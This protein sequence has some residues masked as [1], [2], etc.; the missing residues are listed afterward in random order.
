MRMWDWIKQWLAW[1]DDDDDDDNSDDDVHVNYD[2]DHDDGDD[3][4]DDDDDD[5]DEFGEKSLVMSLEWKQK[6]H[7]DGC[8]AAYAWLTSLSLVA[9]SYLYRTCTEILR[10]ANHVI[11]SGK[12]SKQ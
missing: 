10:I 5:D 2:V 12:I 7:I 6:L 1:R 11:H 8:F 4:Y 3:D 9:E